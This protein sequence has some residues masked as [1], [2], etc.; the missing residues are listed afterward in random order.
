[1]SDR[2][3]NRDIQQEMK[4]S[5][6]DY[7][8]SVLVGRALPDVRDGLKPV[9]RRIL[10]AMKELNLMNNRSF[11]KSARI[12]G[13]CLGKYHPHGDSA[14][15]ESLVRMAQSF[16]LRYPLVQGQGNFGSVDGDRPAAMR[17]TEA[18]LSAIAENLLED[19]EKETVVFVNNFDATTKEPSLLPSKFPNL[20]VNGSS[21]I[22]VGMA[23][24]IPPH[25]LTEITEGLI[26]LIDKPDTEFTEL[27]QLIKGPDFPTGGIIQGTSG[28]LR[29]YA[30]G[31]GAV[32]IRGRAEV[33]EKDGRVALIIKE[34]PF[35]L[36]KSSLMEEIAHL[37]KD[38][39]LSDV[40][41]LRDESDREGMRIVID[42]KRNA[43][44]DVVLNT[45][46]NH[47][48]LET[49]FPIMLVTLVDNQPRT[50]TLKQMMQH[51]IKHRI[52]V[53]RARTTFELKKAEER[54]HILEGLIIALNHTDAVIELIK[55]SA[56]ASIAKQSLIAH[57]QFSAQQAQAVLE[58]RLQKLASL[59]QQQ[60][61]DE[62]THLQHTIK[63][64]QELLGSEQKI[65]DVL[66]DELTTLQKKY[67]D[68]RRTVIEE[69]SEEFTTEDLIKPEDM[70]VTL[71][72]NGYVKRISP[73]EYRQQKRGGRG[74]TA[75]TTRE[76]DF[77]Q[78]LFVANTHTTVLFFTNKGIVH[79]LKV[80]QL[81]SN[82]RHAKG[83]AIVNLLQLQENEKVTACIPVT[84]F[85]QEVSL[86]MATQQGIAKKTS[87]NA[88]ARPRKGGIRAITLDEQDTLIQVALVA[89]NDQLIFSSQQGSAVHFKVSNIR[90]T[91]RS[92]R[93]VRAMRLRNNDIIVGMTV[94][95]QAK[96]LLT[97]TQQGFGKRTPMDEYRLTNR[98][99]SGVINIQTTERNGNV[100]AVLGV[101]DDNEVIF[102][103]KKGIIIR[104]PASGISIIGRNTQGSRIMRLDQ[105][106]EVVAT[107]LLYNEAP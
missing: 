91:G 85:S 44:T 54:C 105:G 13:D 31:R 40:A 89:E 26:A 20:L 19:L 32:R 60:I 35:Q 86:V 76:G 93:G 18:R 90:S 103:S 14:V 7:A 10:Y 80:Y 37:V 67:G 5:Y 95:S 52:A 3:L 64:L 53:I 79:W 97:I 98:G 104:I 65:K 87:L 57:Y 4:S 27:M 39:K 9:H 58:M 106:D 92:A 47:S 84:D 48:R 23:T 66:K 96:T 25:N 8:M 43:N 73:E 70:V 63:G 49:T 94:S 16:S 38:K 46:Y 21:G 81:P 1:M 82:S 15:Y 101:N 50:I 45:L 41:D 88:Y 62:H 77:V 69:N 74:I 24:N 72:A 30:T 102:I 68:A 17:Y 2:V 107:A 33:E 99:G 22:A 75:T 51:F 59:E 42:L 11:R 78:H 6:M 36:K 71:T 56:N 29:A 61:R 28:L 55:K 100:V 12:V 83:Q 34:I